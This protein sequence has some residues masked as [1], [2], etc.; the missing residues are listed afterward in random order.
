MN[1]EQLSKTLFPIGN[2]PKDDVRKIAHEQG[3]DN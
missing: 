2:L 1:Q 3:L